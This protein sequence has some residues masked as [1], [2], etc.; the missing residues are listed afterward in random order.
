MLEK[1]IKPVTTHT[2]AVIHRYFADTLIYEASPESIPARF[3][4]NIPQERDFTM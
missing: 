3:A 1:N 2:T 4:P